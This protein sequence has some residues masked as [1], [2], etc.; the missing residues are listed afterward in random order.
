MSTHQIFTLSSTE[1]SRLSPNGV[2]S[3]LDFTVQNISDTAYVYIGGSEVTT[4][5][6]GY[7]IAPGTAIS[8]E[9]APKDAIYAITDT[10]ESE[11]A[12]LS[13]GLE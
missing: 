13:I 8:V 6:F 3:G 11:I 9:L 2:H 10:N 7:R 5:N 4:T 12:V 1:A